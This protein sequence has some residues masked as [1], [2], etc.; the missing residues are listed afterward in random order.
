MN[1]E[2]DSFPAG[3]AEKLKTYV[4]RLIDPRNGETFYVGKGQGDRVFAHIREQVGGDD[5]NNKLRRI[6]EIRR[7]GFDVAHVIHRHGMDEGTA[8]EVEAALIDAYPGLTN[9]IGGAGSSD[10]GAMHARQIIERY[11]AEPAV[12][13][14]KALL[15]SINRTATETSLYDATRYAW[16][17]S[18][19]KAKEA[20]VILATRQ[21]L[22]VGAFVA[23][24]WLDA[25]PANFPGREGVPGRIGFVGE[26]A[27]PE[28][29]TSYLRKAVPEEYRK[30]G[31]ANP[32]RYTW[33]SKPGGA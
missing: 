11:R 18:K 1:Q 33:G 7:S 9:L 29:A 14:H 21:G 10:Y 32:V 16:K 25:T 20:E 5:P 27:P 31:A 6:R 30:R 17:I 8:F 28:I 12:F 3:V 23:H 24:D 2:S 4:Y 13:Q 15:I 26:D 19:S 22:I